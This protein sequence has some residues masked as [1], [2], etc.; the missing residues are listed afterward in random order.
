[1]SHYCIKYIL[2][3]LHQLE[4]SLYHLLFSYT[5]V[6]LANLDDSDNSLKAYEQGIE[7]NS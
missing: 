3:H 5:V 1:M 6:A 2:L 7:V 4:P